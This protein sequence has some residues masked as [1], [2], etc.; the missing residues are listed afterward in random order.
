MELAFVLAN[1]QN[2]FFVELVAAIRDELD[3]I[4]V[5]SSVH[6]GAF[7]AERDD[8]VYVLVPPHEWFSLQGWRTPPTTSQLARTVLICAEQPGTGFFDDDVRLAELAGAVFDINP[9]S[10][11]EF[12][13]RGIG[14]VQPLSLGW[15]R[16]WAHAPLA[17]DGMPDPVAARDIDA[18]HLG[19]FSAR[20]SIALSTAAPWLSQWRCHLVL[21]DDRGPNATQQ[22]NF[23]TDASKWD[24]LSR[25]RV[26][27]NIHVADRPYFEWMRVVQ[28][29]CC[30]CAVVSEHSVGEAPLRAGEHFMAA[31]VEALGLIAHGLL[32][33]E[34]LRAHVAR[35][36]YDYLRRQHPFSTAVQALAEAAGETVARRRRD[37]PPKPRELPELVAPRAAEKRAVDTLRTQFPTTVTD[38][39]TSV[40]RAAL[41][42]LRLD[43]LGLRRD[44]ARWR[45]EGPAG[46]PVP[47]VEVDRVSRAHGAARPRVSVITPLYNYAHHIE[48]A[49]DSIA[50]GR[51]D[52]V[53]LIVVDDGSTDGS[54]QA[55]RG[56]LQAHEGMA[57]MLVCHPYNRGLGSARNTAL[58]FAR[59]EFAFM[60]DADNEVLPRGLGRLV[61]VLDATPDAA[62]TYGML[63]MFTTEEHVGLLSHFPWELER[64]RTG[65]Y[66]DAMALWRTA[67]LRALGGFTRDSRLHGLEDYDLWCRLAEAG[68]RA[69]L[70]CEVVA[71]YRVSRTSMLSLTS[72]S[73]RNAM[74]V[75]IER[76]PRVM[77]GVDPPL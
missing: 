6:L 52:D 47:A 59:G 56:W 37:G 67:E 2:H 4:G 23:V 68:G 24:L 22:A 10:V 13:R 46:G 5:P 16:S 41:K 42:D 50:R 28:A 39:H 26:L 31:R 61:E 27:L 66:I 74:S 76:Y 63:D 44:F 9:G 11:R 49:L 55:A 21:G 43:L 25:S 1:R 3:Q 75:L 48:A 65:N 29:I 12:A 8:L 14:G 35:H 20:R 53:E 73:A 57:V 51:Y 30:G 17:E 34:D 36:A 70:V 38:P 45:R 33:D 40:L 58:D 77:A 72:I 71:R 54:L 7:P 62:A 69:E 19:I 60:L 15:T 64:F 32:R 18:L